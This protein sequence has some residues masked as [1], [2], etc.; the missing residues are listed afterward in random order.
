MLELIG[1]IFG[2]LLIMSIGL[3]F[4][5][6]KTTKSIIITGIITLFVWVLLNIPGRLDGHLISWQL[7]FYLFIHYLLVGS[8][9]M[10]ITLFI[11]I[12][13]K[14]YLKE[15]Y[16]KKA[17][18]IVGIFYGVIFLITIPLVIKEQIKLYKEYTSLSQ[19]V[20]QVG[21][22]YGFI[23]SKDLIT[24]W[25]EPYYPLKIYPMKFAETF[26]EIKYN[27]R[28][29]LIDAFAK[30][31][32]SINTI[33]KV[34]EV[35]TNDVYKSYEQD[36]TTTKQKQELSGKQYTKQDYCKMIDNKADFHIYNTKELFEKLYF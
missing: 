11:I 3:A 26:G 21:Q 12:K 1:M 13:D 4:D 7:F 10:A 28:Q 31:G 33:Y 35:I 14:L 17:P 18:W 32:E 15:W 16:T 19:E 34:E 30:N 6:N 9:A 25:C 2:L 23:L 24:E 8:I 20:E 36:F 27:S 22:I 5:K 29:F